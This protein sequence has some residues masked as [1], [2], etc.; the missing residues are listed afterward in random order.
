MYLLWLQQQITLDN[1]DM[2][3]EKLA[4][5]VT[6][7]SHPADQSNENLEVITTVFSRA[8]SLIAGG[9]ISVSRSVSTI[10]SAY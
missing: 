6:E 1:V 2:I 7:V 5:I 3:V 9:N 4:D 10:P 8:A